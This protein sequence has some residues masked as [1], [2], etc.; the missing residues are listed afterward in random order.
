MSLHFESILLHIGKD[1]GT[2]MP[3]APSGLCLCLRYWRAAF[4]ALRESYRFLNCIMF[5]L[6]EAINVVLLHFIIPL[7]SGNIVQNACL[8]FYEQVIVD[9]K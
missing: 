5:G 9:P 6:I 4:C 3:P 8:L 2:H 7:E 1:I